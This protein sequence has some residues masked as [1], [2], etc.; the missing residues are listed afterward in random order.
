MSVGGTRVVDGR[1][2]QI[3]K[4]A[5]LVDHFRGRD[6]TSIM[7]ELIEEVLAIGSRHYYHLRA[8]YD[9]HQFLHLA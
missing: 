2:H 9:A 8:S 4:S 7:L 3:E 5:V 1:Y 6:G